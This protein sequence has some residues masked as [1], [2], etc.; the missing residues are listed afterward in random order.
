MRV[1]GSDNE[2]HDYRLSSHGSKEHKHNKDQTFTHVAVEWLRVGQGGRDCTRMM[3]TDLCGH[4]RGMDAE[5]VLLTSV[6]VIFA[7]AESVRVGIW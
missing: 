3:S 7:G 4:P 2:P 1:T 5:S 6:D